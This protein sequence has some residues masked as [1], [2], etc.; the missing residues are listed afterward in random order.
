MNRRNAIDSRVELLG[1]ALVQ[2]HGDKPE[3]AEE[4]EPHRCFERPGGFG[5]PPGSEGE[6]GTVTKPWPTPG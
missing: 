1:L 6:T 3:N 2:Q 4:E 5:L